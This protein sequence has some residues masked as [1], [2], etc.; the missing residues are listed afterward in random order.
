M[1]KLVKPLGQHGSDRTLLCA[2]GIAERAKPAAWCCAIR[3]RKPWL[4]GDTIWRDAV[5]ADTS[6]AARPG[7]GALNAGYAHV[8]GFGPNHH[9]QRGSC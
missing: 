5:E 7:G 8:T 3:R 1:L 9:G 6:Q 2:A 4:V